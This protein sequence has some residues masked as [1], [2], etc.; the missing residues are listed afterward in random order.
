MSLI[1]R[2]EH[3]WQFQDTCNVYVLKSGAECLLIDTGS[4]AIMQ[5][6]AAIGIQRV[7]WILHT[8]HHRDQCW[9]TPIFQKTGAKIAVP[10]YERHLF[11]NVESYWQAR[12]IY[13]NY[14]DS[15]TFFSLGEN[16]QVDAVL[17]DYRTFVW[18]EYD[19]R[20]L[21]A[22]GH[23]YGMVALIAQVDGKKVAFTGDLM[24][25]GGKLYQLHAM[26]YNYGDLLGIEFTMQS[27]LALKKEEV[28]IAFP[29]HGAPIGEVNADITALE[30][31]LEALASIGRLFTSGRNSG[32]RDLDT[33]RESRLQRITEHLLW[34]G[35]YTCSNFYIVLSGNGHAMLVDYGFPSMG[36]LHA[37]SDHESRQALRF[38]QHH[39]DQLREGYGVREI[40]LVLPTHIHDD[41]TCGIPFLQRHFGTQCWA[42]DRIAE[43]I[44]DPAAWASTPCLFDKPIEV[45]RILGDG[46]AFQWRGFDFEVHYAPGQTEFHAIILG[47]IDGKR[48]VFGGDNLFLVNPHARGIER[49]ILVQ[50]TVMRN[51]FQ[52]NMHQH[53]ANGIKATMPDLVCPGHGELIRVDQSRIAEY[54][55]YIERKEAAFRDVVGEPANHFID[56]FWARM[57]PYLSEVRPKSTVKYTIKVRNNL[58]RAAV[59][60]ARILPAFGWTSDGEPES[61]TLEPTHEGEM[62]ITATAP[63]QLDPR[64]R[65]LTAEILIDGVSQ[66][67]VCEALVSVSGDPKTRS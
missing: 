28:E 1:Q 65:L 23:T 53:C 14:N 49:E 52:L 38:V 26:E 22:K 10:E 55:D 59:Y 47:K 48:I 30:S 61:V 2:S 46:E 33:I 44:A 62:T 31:R 56:L 36:H 9:G 3:L 4:G 11:E 63:S 67:P 54:V 41:H 42:L 43:V 66:G 50:S 12:R 51:S 57:L 20:V 37:S 19:F 8:H 17:E 35:P 64:R 24:T 34:A 7:D 13:D 16:I 15:N 32:F 45:Q 6:L 5:H 40:E 60:T 21:P 29:S 18:K 58:E 39:I 25:S 27:I